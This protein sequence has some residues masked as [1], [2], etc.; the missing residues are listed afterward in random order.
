MSARLRPQDHHRS[1]LVIGRHRRRMLVMAVGT[2]NAPLASPFGAD[3]EPNSIIAI[4]Q[5]E[6]SNAHHHASR[7]PFPSPLRP[8][9]P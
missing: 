8:I 3:T 9:S 5:C 1:T 6:P 7:V 4:P 2:G